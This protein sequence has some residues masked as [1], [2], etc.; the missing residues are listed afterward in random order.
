MSLENQPSDKLKF[1]KRVPDGDNRERDVC[2]R[3]DFVHYE[4]PKLV[5]GSVVIWREN[6]K[7]EPQFLL[8]KR[9]ISPRKGYWT[10]PA[11]FMEEK[12]TPEQGAMREAYEEAHAEI[13]PTAL[14]AVYSIPHISQVQMMYVADLPEAKFSVGEESAEVALFKWDDIPW[15]EIAFPS[16]H[17]ALNH[18][19]EIQDKDVF[20]PFTNPPEAE[21][22][23]E[24]L[25][26]MRKK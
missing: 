18:Y 17:W 13:K 20:A 12:E 25:A 4:N 6:L 5:V 1:T 9:A 14:L 8:C 15:N 11:G 19:R 23:F 3:C 24:E 21:G 10:I 22:L 16:V 7:D 26:K 2:D